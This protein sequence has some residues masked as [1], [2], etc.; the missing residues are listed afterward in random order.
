MSPSRRSA[1]SPLP[2]DAPDGTPAVAVVPLARATVTVRV[3]RPRESRISSAVTSVI[4]CIP[5]DT[6]DGAVT[7]APLQFLVESR[8]HRPYG[9]RRNARNARRARRGPPPE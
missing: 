5:I 9:N 3:G 8:T 1:A 7:A 2:V 4:L 6:D